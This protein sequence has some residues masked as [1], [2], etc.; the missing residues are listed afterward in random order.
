[1]LVNLNSTSSINVAE[2][3]RG[4][5]TTT[6]VSASTTVGVALAANPNRAA[7]S[8]YNAGTV[9]VFVREGAVVSA[10]LYEF[11]IP[12]GFLWKEDFA[13]TPRYLGA[14]SVITASGTTNLMVAQADLL[15]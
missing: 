12:P 1:M 4:A 10:S 13:T 6:A 2:D 14:I 9:P 11:I 7:Y 15:T 8:I 3:I 5:K